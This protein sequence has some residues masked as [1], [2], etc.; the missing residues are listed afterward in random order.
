[1]KTL[2]KQQLSSKPETDPDNISSMIQQGGRKF[3]STLKQKA[4]R[5]NN[6]WFRIL[7]LEKRRFIDA[8][9]QTVSRIQSSLLVKVLT[10]LAEKLLQAIGGIRGLVGHLSY[11]MQNY[12]RPLAQKVSQYAKNWGNK[13][14]EKW[15]TDD[16][17][18]RFLTVIEINNL[19]IFRVTNKQ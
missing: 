14:A 19:P 11:E 13:T 17:F 2:T 18:I 1:M 6:S 5:S 10:P 7:S 3:L 9:I 12:G 4:I 8:V 15:A 16:G